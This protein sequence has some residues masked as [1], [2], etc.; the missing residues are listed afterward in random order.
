MTDQTGP[1][2]LDR[3]RIKYPMDGIKMQQK[4]DDHMDQ[5]QS[6]GMTVDEALDLL[7]RDVISRGGF[8]NAINRG[9]VPNIRLGARIIIPRH[10]FTEWL[11]GNNVRPAA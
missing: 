1:D 11:R 9:E 3:F 5:S 4:K 8:Y 10:A 6:A 2:R 7:G